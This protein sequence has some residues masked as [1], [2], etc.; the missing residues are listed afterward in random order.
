MLQELV[1]Q[2]DISTI[3]CSNSELYIGYSSGYIEVKEIETCITA[4]HITTPFS[5]INKIALSPLQTYIMVQHKLQDDGYTFTLYDTISFTHIFTFYGDR[6]LFNPS[7]EEVMIGYDHDFK[8]KNKMMEQWS[9]SKSS[10]K[11]LYHIKQINTATWKTILRNIEDS[12]SDRE[13]SILK[14]VYI[15]DTDKLAIYVLQKYCYKLFIWNLHTWTCEKIVRSKDPLNFFSKS[16]GFCCA[17]WGDSII[18]VR[19][20]KTLK[21]D[22]K[23]CI[24]KPHC[25]TVMTKAY[26]KAILIPKLDEIDILDLETKKYETVMFLPG[27]DVHSAKFTQL[28][29]ISDIDDNFLQNLKRL[30][31]IIE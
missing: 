16:D 17:E 12:N 30:G 2:E 20:L 10:N 6:F 29:P 11:D 24:D 28:H 3:C 14:W 31:A 7:D 23:L 9:I 19:N 1:S 26:E 4:C 13:A 27:I 25:V 18:K 21:Y 22:L 8:Q 5:N 15:P